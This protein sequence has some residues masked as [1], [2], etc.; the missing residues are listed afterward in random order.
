MTTRKLAE[1]LGMN[2]KAITG[3]RKGT[4]R[5][6]WETLILLAEYFGVS[7]EQLFTVK[8][9]E[10]NVATTAPVAKRSN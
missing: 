2:P 1:D 6:D 8:D 5:G 9:K 4:E 10:S 3:L 7:I